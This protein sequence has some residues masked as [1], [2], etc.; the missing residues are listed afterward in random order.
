MHHAEP[1][2]TNEA[3]PT[4][5]GTHQNHAHGMGSAGSTYVL[6]FI[7]RMVEHHTGGLRMSKYVFNIGTPGVGALAISICKEQ[8]REIKAIRLWRKAWYPEAP[9]YPVAFR[10][11]GDPNPMADLCDES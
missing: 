2:N 9:V 8:T 1:E 4:H 6:S 10:P 3:A 11:N 7:D 5:S